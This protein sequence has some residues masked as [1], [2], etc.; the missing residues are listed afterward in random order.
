VFLTEEKNKELEEIISKD[1]RE[2]RGEARKYLA[3]V[4]GKYFSRKNGIYFS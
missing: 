3:S 4:N 2:N 1:Y